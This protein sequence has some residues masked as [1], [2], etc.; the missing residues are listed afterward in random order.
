MH[1]SGIPVLKFFG[2]YEPHNLSQDLINQYAT[3]RSGEGKSQGTIWTE[4]NHLRM[5]VNW[6]RKEKIIGEVPVFRLPRQPPPSHDY[7]TKEEVRACIAAASSAHIRLFVI[8]ACT[9]GARNRAILELT[10]DRVD[11]VRRRVNFATGTDEHHKG[12]ALVPINDTLLAELKAMHEVR[13]S[14]Y[15]IEFRGSPVLSIKKSLERLAKKT[16]LKKVSPHMFRHSAAVWMAE[17]G[18]DMEEIAQFLGHKDVN[19]TRKIY[20]RFSPDYLQKAAKALDL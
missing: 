13:I 9:T 5:T 19:V 11:L 10:W 16:G 6:A 8:L 1:W 15:V 12:R 17:A 2:V 20:A 14:D 18:T 3:L 7:L 4:L